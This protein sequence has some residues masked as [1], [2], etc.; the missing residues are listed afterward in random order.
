MQHRKGADREFNPGPPVVGTMNVT[1]TTWRRWL[2]ELG[3]RRVNAKA[4]AR[5]RMGSGGQTPLFH[6][7]VMLAAATDSSARLLLD[8]GANPNARVTHRKR[9]RDMG[10]AEKEIMREFHNGTSIGYAT[11]F[12]E[13]TRA[14]GIRRRRGAVGARGFMQNEHRKSGGLRTWRWR[15]ILPQSFIEPVQ[16]LHRVSTL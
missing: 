7:V 14:Y 6:T 13:P 10:D 2:I 3:A 11:Q 9:L 15:S 8:S 5:R 16:V 4:A 12:Q 1:T